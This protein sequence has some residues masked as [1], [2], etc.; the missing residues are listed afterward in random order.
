MPT[1]VAAITNTIERL[2]NTAQVIACLLHCGP[3]GCST[4]G[5]LCHNV[6]ERCESRHDP[7]LVF[8]RQSPVRRGKGFVG[9][10]SRQSFLGRR[11]K[12]MI[13]VLH[14]ADGSREALV[15][16]VRWLSAH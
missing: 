14:R 13:L 5:Q 2:K 12:E 1:T 6:D 9:H 7:A 15:A 4:G 3:H 11:R 16:A 10:R 8:E